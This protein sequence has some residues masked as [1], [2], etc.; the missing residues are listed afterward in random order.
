MLVMSLPAM[1]DGVLH[2]Q[3]GTGEASGC[4]QRMQTTWYLALEK[5][6]F[7]LCVSFLPWMNGLLKQSLLG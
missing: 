1:R 5:T 4:T 3:G 7:I 2:E 6:W